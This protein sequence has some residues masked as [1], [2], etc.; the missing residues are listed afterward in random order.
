MR[1]REFMMKD[2]YSFHIDKQCLDKTYEAVKDA[3]LRMFRRMGLDV[4]MVEADTGNIGGTE[5]HEFHVL[6]DCGE[7]TIA[8]SEEDDYACQV[9]IVPTFP[10][11]SDP[12][13]TVATTARID[14]N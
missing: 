4:K 1:A 9:E 13:G 7:G 12:R 8:F 2:G 6:A 11:K 5:S 14:R 10:V 3:Y